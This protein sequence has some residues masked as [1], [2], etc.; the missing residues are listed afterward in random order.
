MKKGDLYDPLEQFIEELRL[1]EY[2]RSTLERYKANNLKFIDWLPEDAELSKDLVMKYKSHLIES[3]GS[4]NSVNTNIVEVDRF[5]KWL[6]LRDF[7]VKKVKMQAKS[8]VED[9]LTREDYK[10]MLRKAKEK[11]DMRMFYIMKILG[12]TGIRVAELSFF[13][14]ESLENEGITVFNKQKEREILLQQDLR[15]E[16]RHYAKEQGIKKGYLFPSPVCEGKMLTPQCIWKNMQNLAGTAR[17]KKKKAHAHSFRHLFAQIYLEQFPSNTP[18]LADIMGHNS[19]E[20]TR[21]YTRLSKAQQRAQLEQLDF[22]GR[23]KKGKK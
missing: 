1:Q 4:T 5:L 6:D 11:G 20:T 9:I 18:Q 7:C 19:L 23:Q 12:M 13:T 15:R 8:S 2:A 14:V 21:K 17:I 3:L 22:T 16:L 10:R